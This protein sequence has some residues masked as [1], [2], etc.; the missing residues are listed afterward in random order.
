MYNIIENKIYVKEILEAYNTKYRILKEHNLNFKINLFTLLLTVYENYT[1]LSAKL[2][3][4]RAFNQIFAEFTDLSVDFKIVKTEENKYIVINENNRQ[5]VLTCINISNENK[6]AE[7][8]PKYVYLDVLTVIEIEKILKSD[9][10]TID[11]VS[12]SDIIKKIEALINNDNFKF[13]LTNKEFYVTDFKNIKYESVSV[14]D[15]LLVDLIREKD[16][17]IS[18]VK[19][20][21]EKYDIKKNIKDYS[22]SNKLLDYYQNNTVVFVVVLCLLILCLVALMYL[23]VYLIN[24]LFVKGYLKKE[25]IY[26]DYYKSK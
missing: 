7:E 25:D 18:S 13:Y 16:E 23:F 1:Y 10:T 15:A 6:D 26:G 21:H 14:L 24:Y 11:Y 9:T 12:I 20:T 5:Y 22:V 8:L 2:Q 17:D 4:T 19:L 3:K